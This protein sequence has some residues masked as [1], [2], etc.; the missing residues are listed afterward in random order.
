M[1]D[2]GT[3]ISDL[4]QAMDEDEDTQKSRSPPSRDATNLRPFCKPE[5]AIRPGCTL[6]RTTLGDR[7]RK[8]GDS[9][10][11]RDAPDLV[12]SLFR[13]PQVAIGLSRNLIGATLG[14]RQ[15]E[16]GDSSAGR[17]ASDLVPVTLGEPEVAIGPGCNL[18]RVPL[19]A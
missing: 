12:V 13:E 8:L 9:S 7:Q 1:R 14:D 10:A 16:L 15:A 5:V 11:G 19:R 6:T 17:D 4:L 2:V 18:N 3:S